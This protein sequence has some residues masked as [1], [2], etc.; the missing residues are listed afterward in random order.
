MGDFFV[1]TAAAAVVDVEATAKRHTL[2]HFVAT[3]TSSSSSPSFCFSSSAPGVQD[4][5]DPRLL[6][7]RV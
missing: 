2:L 5:A 3:P 7:G 4:R 1:F 6:R